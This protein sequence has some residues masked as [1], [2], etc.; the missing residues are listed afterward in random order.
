[1]IATT[2]VARPANDRETWM[3]TP[4]ALLLQRTLARILL[5]A[6]IAVVAGCSPST[7]PPPSPSEVRAQIMRLLPATLTDREGWASDIQAAFAALEIRPVTPNLCATLAVIEQESGFSPDPAVPGL[8]RIA[9]GEIDRRGV[10]GEDGVHDRE[11]HHRD[12]ADEECPS[13]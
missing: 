10:A 1:M 11:G 5:G 7:P 3:S 12:L 2:R 4:K 9:R 8:A 13:S 6:A